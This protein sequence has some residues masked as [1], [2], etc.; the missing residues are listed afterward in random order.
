MTGIAAAM[1]LS[2]V[3]VPALEASPI[4]VLGGAE[5]RGG[6]VFA[7]VTDS[8]RQ[9][10]GAIVVADEGSFQLN[11]FDSSGG[12]RRTVGRRGGGP[13]EF[14]TIS[15]IFT[16]AGDSIWTW[17]MRLHRLT[18]FT[19]QGD[20]A[21]SL[22]LAPTQPGYQ[23]RPVAILGNRILL[24]QVRSYSPSEGEQGVKRDS[25]TL[26]LL[27][28]DGTVE[29]EFGHV[30]ASEVFVRSDGGS[31]S[32]SD[33]PF[34]ADAIFGGGAATWF[35]ADSRS[36]ALQL[37]DPTGRVVRTLGTGF[38]TPVVTPQQIKAAREQRT[39]HLDDP[40]LHAMR[41]NVE[42][43]FRSLPRDL[44]L[45]AM[46]GAVLGDD[47]SVWIAK[48]PR[49]PG[50]PVEWTVFDTAGAPRGRLVLPHNTRVTAAG[51][52]WVLTQGT[53]ELDVDVV[54]LLRVR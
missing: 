42:Q 27:Q 1:L 31:V 26:A 45:P 13:G 33:L 14:Q 5:E 9:A 24:A 4:V 36:P 20:Y 8:A 18:V 40:R 15:S 3:Q 52:D 38:Q 21:R 28:P 7:R 34:G 2:A 37:R 12:R 44:R 19:S 49:M 11:I 22:V 30:P 41:Q 51:A 46:N 53:D 50:E 17:D 32:V 48:H 25:A 29:R 23:P 43:M 47:G 39:R 10:G 16:G 35:A 6:V 54:S